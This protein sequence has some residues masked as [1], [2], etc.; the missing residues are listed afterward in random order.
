MSQNAVAAKHLKSVTTLKTVRN[1]Y[2]CKLR[3]G[4]GLNSQIYY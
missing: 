4:L 2:F 3:L 1:N